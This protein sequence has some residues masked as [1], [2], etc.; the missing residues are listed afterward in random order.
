MNWGAILGLLLV[1]FSV[2]LFLLGKS[3]SAFTSISHI[4]IIGI[5]CLAIIKKKES[6]GG[7]ISFGEGVS[8]ATWVSI[9][10]GVIMAF[11]TF[12]DLTFID[13][14]KTQRILIQIEDQMYNSGT[15]ND[16]IEMVMGIYEKVFTPGILA[17]ATLIFQIIEGIVIGLVAS[18]I[19]KK[20]DTSFES[21]F[22]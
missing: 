14:D 1:V 20:Q 16:Q 7:F 2:I 21:N 13:A 5:L 9:F 3:E 19:L 17:F 10:A 8:V 6:N 22:K 15:P 4:I 12:A 11:Y 18:A